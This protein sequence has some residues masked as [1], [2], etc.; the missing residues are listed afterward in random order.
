MG[1]AKSTQRS[2]CKKSNREFGFQPH[3]M[4]VA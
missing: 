1:N 4:G 3:A 2:S